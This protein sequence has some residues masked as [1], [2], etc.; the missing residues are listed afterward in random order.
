MQGG[1]VCGVCVCFSAVYYWKN[2]QWRGGEW[3]AGRWNEWWWWSWQTSML[4]IALIKRSWMICW[5]SA[6]AESWFLSVASLNLRWMT[7]GPGADTWSGQTGSSCLCIAR[8]NVGHLSREAFSDKNLALMRCVSE[9][10]IW[11]LPNRRWEIDPCP[12]CFWGSL[13]FQHVCWIMYH[14]DPGPESGLLILDPFLVMIVLLY[15]LLLLLLLPK[16]RLWLR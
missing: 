14:P 1:V 3:V 12:E 13:N 4:V 11:F 10:W 9:C 15:L 2:E 8:K 7:G 6:S 5:W 16:L